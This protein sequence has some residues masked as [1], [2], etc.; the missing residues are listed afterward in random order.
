VR[1]F[2][3]AD[4]RR[5]FEESLG[6]LPSDVRAEP[7]VIRG[8]AGPALVQTANRRSDLLVIG[9]GGRGRVRHA[10]RAETAR[11]CLADAAC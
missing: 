9:A 6:G 4:L 5:A 1:E 2:V 3:E 8:A 11:Y 7:Y 10:L